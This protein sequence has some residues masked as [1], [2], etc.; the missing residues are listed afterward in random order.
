MSRKKKIIFTVTNDL[1]YD[2]R[3]DRICTSMVKAGYDVTLVGRQLPTSISLTHKPYLQVRLRC[4]NHKGKLFYI[5]YNLRLYKFLKQQIMD[6]V[7]AIDLDTIVPVYR[8]SVEKGIPRMYDA[9]EYFTEMIEVKSRWHI[10]KVWKAIEQ[11]YVPLFRSGY[12]VGRAIAE[13]FKMEY[14]VDYAVVRNV[15]FLR[16]L[17]A[18]N[19]LVSE[20]VTNI[21]KKFN[22]KTPVDLPIIL[23]Q[24]A[25]NYGRSLPELLMAMHAV[26]ARLLI[27]GSGNMEQLIAQRIKR[28]NLE[29]KV[30][31][32]GNLPPSLLRELTQ[33]CFAGITI[34]DA[35]SKNQYY[36]LGNKFFD[37][38]MAG[39]PQVCVNYPEYAEILKQ[40]PVAVPVE[41][42]KPESIVNALNKLISDPVLYKNLQIHTHEAA[43]VL[44]W[45]N[46]ERILWKC[47]HAL[48]ANRENDT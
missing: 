45:E 21:L 46:E 6:A 39:K 23:Y 18:K 8:V 48:F 5:E 10:F 36:S 22:E 35:L 41:S 13:E 44:N 40:H 11:K 4:I 27:A 14:G 33:H 30:M 34:F 9:H 32:C 17:D 20:K 26:N 28:E 16:T 15:P 42:T 43:L 47:W 29:N 31:M 12:T 19:I 37:Y 3:M 38:I 1:T 25:V 2:Q 7:C 24:G